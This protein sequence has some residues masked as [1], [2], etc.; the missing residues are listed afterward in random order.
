[1][2]L[3][4]TYF[5]DMTTKNVLPPEIIVWPSPVML[6]REFVDSYEKKEVP[7]GPV[8]YVVF[9]RTYARKC[10][11]SAIGAITEE[12]HQTLERCVNAILKMSR[13]TIS[14]KEAE[15]LYD[16]LF[17]LRGSLSGRALW[18]LGSPTV[19]R[20]GGAS[21]INCWFAVNSEPKAFDFIFDMLMLGGGVGF[22]IQKEHVY[23]LPKIA[24][25]VK[26]ER[27][28]TKDA[29]FIVPDSREGWVE[30][31]HKVFDSHLHTGKAF[32][33]STICIRGKGT[34]INGFGGV[35]SGPE[36]LCKGLEDIIAILHYR[37]GK[38][39]RPVD[40]LDINNII[41]SIV[42]AG[43]VRRSAE[44]AAGDPDD[45]FFLRA[46][47]WSQGSIPSW[48]AMSN[49]TVIANKF[50]HLPDEF[51]NGY[52]PQEGEPYGLFN[53]DL[54]RR[55]GRLIDNHRKDSK[56]EGTNP[57]AEITLEP[58]ECCNLAEIFLPNI[59][60]V[61]QFIEVA[62]L[63]QKVQKLITTLP[64]HWKE[65]ED[66]VYRN[67][68]LGLG[69]TGVY[70]TPE[71]ITKEV[72]NEVYSALEAHDIAYSKTLS[73]AFNQDIR[74]SI[75]LTTVKP[76]GTLSLLAGVAPG[77]HPEYAPYYIRRIRMAA[78]DP[79]LDVCKDAGYHIE[80][81]LKLDGTKDRDTSVVSFPIKSKNPTK[82]AR[83]I[84][85]I[86]MLEMVKHLQTFWSDNSVSCTVY[87]KPEELDGVKEWLEKNYNDNIKTISFLLHSEHGFKQAPLEEITELDWMKLYSKTK[88]VNRIHDT[89]GTLNDNLECTNGTCPIK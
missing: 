72:L 85:A 55:K 26:I 17:H 51:W 67:R 21:L 56:V 84:T 47:R 28:D 38:R 41:G 57:C 4:T 66:V 80:P 1:M 11:G 37:H 9:K 7:W 54:S 30:L 83:N 43:N 45:F 60:S 58:Y 69:I 49:N 2:S 76:S 31:L 79:L 64:Y 5:D 73:H 87:Y 18:Q 32:S 61:E 75:K 82:T 39:L 14:L 71:L 74:P 29:D 77:C 15:L 44:L 27:K 81:V 52:R 10:V 19:D 88:P 78:N 23:Q 63:L 42:V 22:N 89:G 62:C 25:K 3:H 12:W 34:P 24:Y 40:V 59:Q 35:A 65:V 53:R 36:D 50:D 16:H 8:G 6:S 20:L 68:R 86:E 33:Y 70:Q 46:K 48:R 13:G